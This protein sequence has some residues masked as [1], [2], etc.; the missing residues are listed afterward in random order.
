MLELMFLQQ[1][2]GQTLPDP[3]VGKSGGAGFL[4]I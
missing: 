2:T 4:E 3:S 1:K